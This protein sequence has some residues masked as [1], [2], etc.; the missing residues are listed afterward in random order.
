M[1][2]S[3]EPQ[4]HGIHFR[5]YG[6]IKIQKYQTTEKIA[7]IILKVEQYGFTTE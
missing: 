4:I 5:M 2:L 7:V 6:T 3:W 1:A